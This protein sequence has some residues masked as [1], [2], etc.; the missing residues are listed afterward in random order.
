MRALHS[1]SQRINELLLVAAV[2]APVISLVISWHTKQAQW[3]ER[4]GSLTTLFAAGVSYRQIARS[5]NEKRGLT[6]GDLR[7]N[8]T[9]P[10]TR[11]TLEERTARLALV[12]VV[13]GTIIWGYGQPILNS[14]VSSI[15]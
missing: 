13:V 15:K 10:G 2:L 6:M 4:S 1:P 11:T 5:E 14:I 12:L 3:F 7:L 9:V 8:Q